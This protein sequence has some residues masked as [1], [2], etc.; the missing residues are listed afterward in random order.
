MLASTIHWNQKT[1]DGT[2]ELL[3]LSFFWFDLVAFETKE[4]SSF[5]LAH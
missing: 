4:V 2:I 1:S 3:P 5:N